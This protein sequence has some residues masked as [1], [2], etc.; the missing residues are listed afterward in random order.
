LPEEAEDIQLW[1]GSRRFTPDIE[2]KQRYVE[3]PE[4][5]FG[6]I[7]AI[8][9]GLGTGKTQ[10]LIEGVIAKFAETH[11]ILGLSYRNSLLLQ[12]QAK[13]KESFPIEVGKEGFHGSNKKKNFHHLQNDLKDSADDALIMDPQSKILLCADSLIHFYPSSFDG[14]IVFIDEIENFI[15]QLLRGNTAISNYRERVKDLFREIVSRAALV[16]LLDGHLSDRSCDYLSKLAPEKKVIKFGNSYQGNRGKVNFYQG[17]LTDNGYSQDNHSNFIEHLTLNTNCIA[18]ASDSQQK[19]EALEKIKQ[20][21][22][23]KTFRLDSQN[24]NSTIG[25]EFLRNPAKFIKKHGIQVLL[26]SPSA[27]SGLSVD[28][29]NYF[30]DLYL[31][32]LGVTTVNTM[33][34]MPGRVRDSSLTIHAFVNSRGLGMESVGKSLTPNEWEKKCKELYHQC[35]RATLGG[36]DS[37]VALMNAADSLKEISSDIHF[38]HESKLIALERI[39]RKSLRRLVLEGMKESGYEIYLVS[40]LADC[41]SEAKEELKKAQAKVREERS[42]AIFDSP[43]IESKEIPHIERNSERTLEEKDSVAKRKLL[44]RI[45]GI[46]EK[47]TTQTTEVHISSE[48]SKEIS[49]ARDEAE[50]AKAREIIKASPELAVHNLE[51]SQGLHLSPSTT[52]D[53]T[54]NKKACCGR[55]ENAAQSLGVYEVEGWVAVVNIQEK[56]P[57]GNIAT[58]EMEI[59]LNEYQV[60]EISV[61]GNEAETKKTCELVGERLAQMEK[62]LKSSEDL[63][64]TPST[65]T[66]FSIIKK[67]PC[68]RPESAAESS[69][70]LDLQVE[71]KKPLFDPQLIE[72]VRYQDPGYIRGIELQWLFDHPGVALEIQRHWWHRKL[73]QFT[74]PSKDEVQKK[75]SLANFQSIHLRVQALHKLNLSWFLQPGQTWN[76]KSPEVREIYEKGG[77]RQIELALGISRGRKSPCQYVG[78]L[79]EMMRIPTKSK[80]L[81]IDGERIR[82]YSVSAEFWESSE[83][84]AIYECVGAKLSQKIEDALD[85]EILAERL[86]NAPEQPEAPL[87]EEEVLLE[88]PV[89]QEA[90]IPAP[91]NQWEIDPP[92]IFHE[93]NARL[94]PWMTDDLKAC[95]TRLDSCQ[96]ERDLALLSLDFQFG[97]LCQAIS[98]QSDTSRHKALSRWHDS[99]LKYSF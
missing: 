54:I 29:P 47:C 17:V 15:E 73:N 80:R 45:P 83:R 42:Q 19:L 9:S 14:K 57:N 94:K 87:I 90:I 48:R 63:N 21:Q 39:E 12:F 97:I 61:I 58:K 44:N 25:K 84:E 88:P 93:N 28:L 27:D 32:G 81:S 91:A 38:E 67:A 55:P 60:R 70:G 1:R 43:E 30:T 71:I 52:W 75:I 51:L 66:D 49:L 23:F 89:E 7:L 33:L 95:L 85:W 24:S 59:R 78:K 62:G 13:V 76:D 37:S 64:S 69:G 77:D 68:G 2:V 20:A 18:I 10:G 22:G 72:R 56:D 34:Q 92:M 35:S 46:E 41:S 8:G 40:P 3:L 96:N 36:L 99:I 26:Y 74:D 98:L 79:L 82:E 65:T 31:L 53:F 5:E 50:N 16:I 6:S 86:E 4:L 11:G